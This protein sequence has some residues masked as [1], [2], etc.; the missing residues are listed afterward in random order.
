MSADLRLVGPAAAC[1]ATTAAAL[2]LPLPATWVLTA[3]WAVALAG[4]IALVATRA[5]KEAAPKPSRGLDTRAVAA[6][7]VGICGIAAAAGVVCALR[8]GIAEGSPVRAV[9]GKPVMTLK[10][11]GDPLLFPRTGGARLPVRIL[12][13]NGAAQRPVNAALTVRLRR[14]PDTT[15][16]QHLS[17]RVRVRPPPTGLADR[18]TAAQLTALEAPTITAQAPMWQRWAGAV[19]ERLRLLAARAVPPRAAGLFPGVILG[20]T[21]DLDAQLRDNFRAASLTHLVAVSGANFSLVCGAVVLAVRLA[22]A[23]TRV[24][25]AIGLLAMLVFVILVRPTDSVLRAAVMGGVGLLGALAARR[26]QALPALGAAVIAV[27]L[28]WPQMAVAPGFAL[29]VVATLGLV[30]WAAP[31]RQMLIR[32][33]VPEALAVLLSM[34]LTAQ[35]LTMPLV[36]AIS[37][38]LSLTAVPAN[39]LVAPVVPVIALLGTLAAVVGAVGPPDGGGALAAE[40]L[41]R[42]TGPELWWLIQVADTLGGQRWSAPEVPG[43]HVA[44]VLVLAGVFVTAAWRARSAHPK[45]RGASRR[46]RRCRVARWSSD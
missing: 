12:E 19:R 42:A 43:W 39:L 26:A 9:D 1:W 6:T 40:W 10:V 21:G 41:I 23:S 24:T 4:G 14:L 44:T 38:R 18:L 35:I 28:F 30:L 25:V 29:S 16:G 13:V 3:M 5:G 8:I 31:L 20:D 34:T 32:G 11:T 7:M 22:G 37:D 27:L 2:C 45:A 17:V 36:I 15:P 33:G 46:P